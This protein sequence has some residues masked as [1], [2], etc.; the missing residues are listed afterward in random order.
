M[1]TAGTNDMYNHINKGTP[2]KMVKSAPLSSK[3]QQIW[4]LYALRR[5]KLEDD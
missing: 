3:R 2:N 5:T 4:A 1:L